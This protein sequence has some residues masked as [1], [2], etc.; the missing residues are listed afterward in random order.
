[1]AAGVLVGAFC[2][3]RLLPRVQSAALRALFVAVLLWISA[4]MLLKG[5]R[6]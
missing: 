6:G 4:Q 2:G 5:L 3:S 1:V